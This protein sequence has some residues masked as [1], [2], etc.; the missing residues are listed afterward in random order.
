ML[1]LSALNRKAMHRLR[2][3]DGFPPAWA[4]MPGLEQ[5]T[6]KWIERLRQER[7]LLAGQGRLPGRIVE[8]L[9]RHIRTEAREH[10][11]DPDFPEKKK[12]MAVWALHAFNLFFRSYH[13]FLAILEPVLRRAARAR[14]GS[15][16]L[17]E[18]A[19]GSGEFTLALAKAARRKNLP[20]AITGSDYIEAYLERG[21]R[22]AASRNVQASF[23]LVNAYDMSN[24]DEDEYD[25]VFIC[26]SLHHFTP[27]QLAMMIAQARRVS[28]TA[29][30]GIDGFR[31]VP[32]LFIVPG[33]AL[34][35]LRPAFFHDA[36]LTARK[37]YSQPELELIGRIAAP[38][39][40][41]SV[42]RDF[43]AFSVLMASW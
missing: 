34:A 1:Q 23:R 32:L 14:G 30:V 3:R 18:L 9:D 38:G 25:V 28:T 36:L 2:A 21:R 20:V 10:L 43:P 33:P 40:R 4:D 27:G 19:S 22:A 6:N 26:Q 41:V 13:R 29:F 39:A 24:I 16:R 7:E 11:D 31:S 37:L 35:T 17:L 8:W 5:A 42:F 12:L 15:A